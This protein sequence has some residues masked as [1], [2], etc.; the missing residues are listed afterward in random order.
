M[1]LPNAK[2]LRLLRIGRVVRLFS[3]MKNGFA[4][5]RGFAK[6][7]THTRALTTTHSAPSFFARDDGSL[8][9]KL[10]RQAHTPVSLSLSL[11]QLAIDASDILSVYL[12]GLSSCY[13]H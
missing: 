8:S 10:S 3:G 9:L 5:A 11:S 6:S 1:E 7:H 13:Q 2:L 4:N 12:A